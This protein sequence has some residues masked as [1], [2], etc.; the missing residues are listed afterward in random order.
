MAASGLIDNDAATL[1]QPIELEGR[2]ERVEDAGVIA[3]MVVFH[4]DLPV[5]LINWLI[6]P[7]TISLMGLAEHRGDFR[8]SCFRSQGYRGVK[9]G[10]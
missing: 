2:K 7:I 6:R 8:S 9:R 10:E 1:R 3:V 4:I 5:T